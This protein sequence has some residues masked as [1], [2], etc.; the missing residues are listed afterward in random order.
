LD[1]LDGM[2][3]ADAEINGTGTHLDAPK[4]SVPRQSLLLPKNAKTT[5]LIALARFKRI[6][7]QS[8]L[9]QNLWKLY[10]PS[11]IEE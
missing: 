4:F 10:Q 7:G 8:V 9:F 3:T 2:G 6:K 1:K 5:R 11:L